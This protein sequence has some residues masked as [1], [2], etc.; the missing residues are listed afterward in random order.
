VGKIRGAMVGRRVYWGGFSHRACSLAC[1]RVLSQSL[2]FT[3]EPRLR[4]SAAAAITLFA[5]GIKSVYAA[6]SDALLLLVAR[7]QPEAPKYT[8]TRV[9]DKFDPITGENYG[10]ATVYKFDR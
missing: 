3:F 2:S 10:P 7:I 6:V 9:Q 1:L 5:R 4:I 8:E